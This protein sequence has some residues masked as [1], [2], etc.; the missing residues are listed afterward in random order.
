LT[1]TSLIPLAFLS[2]CS[3]SFAYVVSQPTNQR[4]LQGSTVTVSWSDPSQPGYSGEDINVI[5]QLV[6][7]S[8][9]T[10]TTIATNVTDD[11]TYTWTDVSS[12]LTPSSLYRIVISD[13]DS[14]VTT[15]FNSSSYFSIASSSGSC[16]GAQTINITD[17][18]VEAVLTEGSS[19]VANQDCTWLIWVW[20]DLPLNPFFGVHHLCLQVD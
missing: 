8:T 20:A 18:D 16:S 5:V 17:T 3:A 11:G 12:S 2:K 10:N 6:S 9:F 1:L 14:N 7:G 13:G 19:Y 15:V 4:V